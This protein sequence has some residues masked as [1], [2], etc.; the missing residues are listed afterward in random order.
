V[1]HE[2]GTEL[3]LGPGDA[4]RDRAR[5]RCMGARRRALRRVWVRVAI[6]RGVRAPV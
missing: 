4:L 1:S 5:S 3:E 2:D 6:R